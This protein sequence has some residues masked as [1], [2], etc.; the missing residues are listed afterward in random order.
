MLTVSASVGDIPGL[1]FE[2]SGTV[3]GLK[4]DCGLIAQGKFAVVDLAGFGVTVGGDFG[5]GKVQATLIGG[6]VKVD[7]QGKVIDPTDSTTPVD[8]RV[9]FV[10]IDGKVEIAGMGL[11]L[12]LALSELGPL[13][14]LLTVKVP[15]LIE[16]T[17]GLTINELTGGIEF[18]TSLPTISEP[19]ELR[20]KAFADATQVD[21]AT[22]MATVK[23]QVATQ[24]RLLRENPNQSSW[25]SA[26]TSPMVITAGAT[27]SSS[28]A[29]GPDT[30]NAKVQL[31]VA[32]DGKIFASGK[33]RF[34][35][36]RLVV[37]GKIYAD[38]TQVAK[39]NAKI[40]FL[41][42]APVIEDYP[43]LRFLVVK[44]KFEMRFLDANG[45]QMDFGASTNPNPSANLAF[46]GSGATLGLQKMQG[47]RYIDVEFV[48]GENPLDVNSIL[49][50]DAELRL[51]VPAG[52]TIE[53]SGQP[54][55]VTTATSGSVY[56]YSLPDALALEPGGYEVEFISGSFADSQGTTN[57]SERETFTL[58]APEGHL[59]GPKDGGQ[60]DVR[61]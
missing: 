48:D 37:K 60:I 38:L 14:V 10:G 54:T 6:I 41:G 29:G 47:N 55:R 22:W 26:F 56:R 16:P 19:E 12:R 52:T 59:A 49:D 40:L 20:G 5:G 30:F 9:L 4:I 46:P 7:A 61:R 43:D 18:Y 45:Q 3:D 24:V 31:R 11:E 58:A 23:Q 39:G 50:D 34:F 33:F 57:A 42:E 8:E 17:S 15:I 32:T 36:N 25:A 2:L 44:G 35:N 53:I 28:N 13:G 1:P 51:H 27:L 21:E